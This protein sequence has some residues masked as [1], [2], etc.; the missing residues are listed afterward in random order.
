M[1]RGLIIG[2][3]FNLVWPVPVNCGFQLKNVNCESFD[4]SYWDFH[5][6]EMKIVRRGVAAF[7]MIWKIYK[8]PINNAIINVSLYKKSNGYRPFLFNQSVDF[9]YYM[10]NPQ[11]HPL[12]S[13]LHKAFMPASNIN[14]SCP[15]NHDLI[16]NDFIYNKNDFKDLPIPNGEYMIEAKFA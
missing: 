8:L 4:T 12:M 5:R 3:V 10:R 11:A 13:M 1:E 9:C 6:C 15:Y 16:I 14:H 7:Y 2:I